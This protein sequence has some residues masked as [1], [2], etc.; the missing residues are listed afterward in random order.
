[1]ATS[2][3]CGWRPVPPSGFAANFQ[4]FLRDA[5]VALYSHGLLAELV[6]QLRVESASASSCCPAVLINAA[7]PANRRE[8]ARE[9]RATHAGRETEPF[10]PVL[11]PMRQC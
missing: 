7:A 11:P 3:R 9:R 5:H 10:A 8:A 2:W 6:V 1:M 4:R